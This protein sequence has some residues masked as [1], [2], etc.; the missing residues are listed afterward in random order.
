LQ[1]EVSQ[2]EPRA[3]LDG[4]ADGLDVIRRLVAQAPDYLGE[5]GLGLLALEVGLGQADAVRSLMAEAGFA[6]VEVVPDYAGIDR[7]IVGRSS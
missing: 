4:G 1:P 6:R 2:A 7:V 3:A 5:A